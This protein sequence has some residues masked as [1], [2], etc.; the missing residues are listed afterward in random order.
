MPARQLVDN[1]RPVSLFLIF[2]KIFEKLL[3]GSIY[4]PL[5]ENCY[6]ASNVGLHMIALVR[7]NL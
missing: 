2:L 3:F 7:T 1:Y 6:P 4:V 5:D